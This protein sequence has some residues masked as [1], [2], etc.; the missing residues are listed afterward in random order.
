[1]ERAELE[2][3]LRAIFATRQVAALAT[4]TADGRPWVRFVTV[5][6]APDLSLRIVTGASTRK[7][8]EIRACPHVHLT[9][10]SLKPPDDSVYLQIAGRA[11]ISTDPEEKRTLWIDEYLR[12]FKGADDPEYI[13][14]RVHP[15]LIEYTGPDSP[16]A[17]VWRR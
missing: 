12:Y 11:E 4:V 7:A 5:R 13:V 6:M 1:M 16:Q 3:R 9:C 10:G 2:N 8:A 17:S 15:D 14:L